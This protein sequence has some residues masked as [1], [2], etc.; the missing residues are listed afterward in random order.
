[1]KKIIV[2]II[3][4]IMN[5]KTFC[6]NSYYDAIQLRQYVVNGKFIIPVNANDTAGKILMEKYFIIL[7]S[8]YKNNYTRPKEIHDNLADFDIESPNADYNPFLAEL[9]SPGSVQAFINEQVATSKFQKSTIFSSVASFNV[10]NLADGLARF[11]IKRGKEE[12]NILFF[13]RMKD[14][15]DQNIEAR[16]LFP[17]T[18]TFLRGIAA[19]RYSELLQSMREAFYKDI[20]NLIVNLNLL[21]DL[22]KYQQLLKALPEIRLAIR[23]VKIISELSQSNASMHPAN[24]ISH[25]ANLN[26]WGE[27]NINLKSSWRVLD[28]ISESVR[29]MDTEKFIK[30]D[31]IKI[32]S[33]SF[34]IRTTALT[35]NIVRIDSTKI[36]KGTPLIISSLKTQLTSS[37]DVA[38][39][40]FSDFNTNILKDTITL[41]IYLG[42]LYQKMKG[43]T[44]RYAP[45]KE[46][47]V[48]QFMQDNSNNILQISD[49][50]ENFLVLA[51]DVEHSIKDLKQKKDYGLTNEDYY[52]YIEKAINIIDYG[53]KIANTIKEGIA[54]DRY[55]VMARNANNLFKN[56][57]TK[58]YNAA[59]MNTY[60]ILQEVLS[61]SKAAIDNKSI[62]LNDTAN[63]ITV[64]SKNLFAVAKNAVNSS[65][66]FE[67][68]SID[69]RSILVEGILKYGN[70]IASIVKAEKPEE[71]AAA[72]EAAV[73][74]AGSSSIKKNTAWN[75]SLNAYIG[76]YIKN[77]VN[78][79]DKIDGN[80]SKV[81]V[82]APV[83]IAI[84][85][86][87]GLYNNGTTIGALS[88]YATLIDVGAIAGYRLKNDSTSLDQKVT[89]NDIFTPGGYLVY[90]IGLPIKSLS[91]V[92]L[93]V[94]YGWQYGSRLYYKK[95]DGKLAISDK[96]RWKSNWFIAIDIPLANFWTKNYKNQN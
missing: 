36:L 17:A 92:P 10:T 41:K 5:Q 38:W 60:N 52:T 7:N 80:N 57:Y 33:D 40:S 34:I 27:M 82:T 29:K 37:K 72:I 9:L 85:K 58:N 70:L 76:G 8:Y 49:L 15:L 79:T 54:D 83:G 65:N 74:P 75:I 48:Q 11:L 14:F 62:V 12:L 18:S 24:L 16:T 89:I 51:N 39:I 69:K 35:D 94:G 23:S 26:E 25:F 4:L 2:M 47:S 13:Q 95:D 55:I 71:A 31:T 91:Y 43:I 3:L 44:F 63:K 87:L 61:K 64:S 88:L 56:I 1:M 6:Q 22:P 46:I 32:T 77:S 68:D 66:F 20:S 59:V 96:S 45:N 28:K 21:I 93:S 84:S 90:G 81:G 42:L 78:N 53:F 19:Y 73:L 67:K 50:V 86:G 30:N